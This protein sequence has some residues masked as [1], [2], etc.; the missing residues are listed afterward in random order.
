MPTRP[1]ASRRAPATAPA[2]D[3]FELFVVDR[4]GRSFSASLVIG[5]ADGTRGGSAQVVEPAP[6]QKL[7]LGGTARLDESWTITLTTDGVARS[8]GHAAAIVQGTGLLETLE[9]ITAALAAAINDDLASGYTAIANGLDLLITDRTG[10]VFRAS[11]SVTPVLRPAGAVEVV[12]GQDAQGND[13]V[14]AIDV[15]IGHRVSV[16]FGAVLLPPQAG[17]TWSVSVNIA[18]TLTTR[19]VLVQAGDNLVLVVER[20]AAALRSGTS[21]TAQASGTTLEV[22]SG[23]VGVPVI[24]ASRT[25]AGVNPETTLLALTNAAAS[26]APVSGARWTLHLQ[27]GGITASFEQ[28]VT[29]AQTWAQ[30][31]DAFAASINA[32]AALPGAP[33]TGLVARSTSDGHLLLVDIAGRALAASASLVPVAVTAIDAGGATTTLVNLIGTP[34]ANETWRL[35]INDVHNG[36][37]RELSYAVQRGDV[38]NGVTLNTA[39]DFATALGYLVANDAAAARYTA[40]VDGSRVILIDRLGQ[41]FTTRLQAGAITRSEGTADIALEFPLAGLTD[42]QAAAQLQTQLVAL[43][44]FD[45]LDVSAVRGTGDITF[46]VRFVRDQAG[47]DK[48][49]IRAVSSTGLV[50]SPNASVELATATVRHGAT[51]NAGINNLQTVTINPNVTGGSFTLSFR[52]ENSSRRVRDLGPPRRSTP[53]PVRWTCTRPSAAC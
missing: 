34:A 14:P 52:V 13:R 43:Y 39:A 18:G 12:R 46:T 3:S 48:D 16:S 4:S 40:L 6:T 8:Y 31:T 29:T 27:V 9:D 53:R 32:A 5:L 38:V 47:L 1:A 20:L 44:G 15:R 11:G 51:V 17:E 23:S 36:L 21:F 42:A 22:I 26:G 45:D 25:S 41:I 30:I 33:L 37:P 10:E 50:P 35:R 24:V 28:A 2:P 7:T 49:P 19:S